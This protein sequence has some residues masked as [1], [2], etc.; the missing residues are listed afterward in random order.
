MTMSKYTTEV[1]FICETEYG[2]KESVGQAKVDEI[3]TVVAP[4]IFDF[5]FPIFDETY[6]LAL[7]KKILRHFY[8]REI[9]C[10]TVGLW[11]LRLEDKMNEIMPFLNKYYMMYVSELN[12]LYNVDVEKR[13]QSIVNKDEDRRN[14]FNNSSDTNTEGHSDSQ[15]LYSDTPQN[16]LTSVQS[17]EYLTNATVDGSNSNGE[18]HAK[19]NGWDTSKNSAKDVNDYYETVQGRNSGFIGDAWKKFTEGFRNV[20]KMLFKELEELFFQLW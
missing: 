1:R 8:T 18:G 10:E 12:P 6:R 2:L 20:D 13:G 9:C 17:G 16:G 14:E 5:D 11:K 3:L 7:E 15:R 4:K 19:S